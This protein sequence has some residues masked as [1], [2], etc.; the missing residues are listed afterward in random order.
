MPLFM[1]RSRVREELDEICPPDSASEVGGTKVPTKQSSF[2]LF[3]SKQLSL[4]QTQGGSVWLVRC[5]FS[6][7]VFVLLAVN[8]RLINRRF[9]CT[10]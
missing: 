1:C 2:R 10:P 8:P 3:E 6:G 5:S 7:Q 9:G 4:H